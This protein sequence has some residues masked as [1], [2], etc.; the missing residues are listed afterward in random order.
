MFV[1]LRTRLHR[2][3]TGACTEIPALLASA[4]VVEPLAG[5]CFHPRED[6]QPGVLAL[7]EGGR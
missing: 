1:T 2:D 3:A 4:A 7:S 5:Y 6:R